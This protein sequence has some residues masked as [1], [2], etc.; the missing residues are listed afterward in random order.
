MEKIYKTLLSSAP[1]F[2]ALPASFPQPIFPSFTP[3]PQKLVPAAPS[4]GR[5]PWFEVTRLPS[6]LNRPFLHQ[7]PL[8]RLLSF[9]L[10]S[11]PFKG[12][13]SG[14]RSNH[15]PSIFGSETVPLPPPFSTGFD[16][17]QILG[18]APAASFFPILW[19]LQYISFFPPS[20]LCVFLLAPP[21]NPNGLST[22]SISKFLSL[23]PVFIRPS[24]FSG[25]APLIWAVFSPFSHSLSENGRGN[26]FES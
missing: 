21:S 10:G 7:R 18:F 26:Y 13:A 3:L 12:M 23:F 15:P 1:L 4:E 9:P 25:R 22:P 17:P 16:F 14:G 19:A 8:P 2:G 11:P 5:A 24:F 20:V 6:I